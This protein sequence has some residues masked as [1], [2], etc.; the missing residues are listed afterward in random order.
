MALSTENSGALL[1]VPSAHDPNKVVAYFL[2]TTYVK[3]LGRNS[4]R[5]EVVEISKEDARQ[6]FPWGKARRATDEE[7]TGISE[8]SV[9]AEVEPEILEEAEAE[10]EDGA[11][12]ENDA[13]G[14][15]AA[16]EVSVE[17]APTPS[18]G[19]KRR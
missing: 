9:E 16:A 19:R 17:S 4:R 7:I 15:G 12:V 3:S 1:G 8:V 6:L 10:S 18:R 5:D 2:A 14:E 13:V 11:S